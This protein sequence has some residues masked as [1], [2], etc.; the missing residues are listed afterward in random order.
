M[1]Q[2][3]TFAVIRVLSNNQRV[4]DEPSGYVGARIYFFS[5]CVTN[6]LDCIKFFLS[7]IFIQVVKIFPACYGTRQFITVFTKALH[8]SL[9]WAR[10]IQSIISH[11]ISQRSILILSSHVRLDLPSGLFPSGLPTKV[12]THFSSHQRVLYIPSISSSLT[13]SP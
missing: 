7:W 2:Y 13:R 11:S 5:R 10:W 4:C 12:C 3:I 9:L 6:E 1:W 8:W